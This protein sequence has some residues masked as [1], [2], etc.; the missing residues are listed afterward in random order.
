MKKMYFIMICIVMLS[1]FTAFGQSVVSGGSIDVD[2][3]GNPEPL[4]AASA[5]ETVPA[6]TIVN[7]DT[8]DA[9]AT[10]PATVSVNETERY[11]IAG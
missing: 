1:T 5:S 3:N 6:E 7:T 11:D 9:A 4:P 8:G 2:N 10:K